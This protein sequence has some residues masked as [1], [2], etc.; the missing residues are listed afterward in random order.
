MGTVRYYDNNQRVRFDGNMD[1]CQNTKLTPDSMVMVYDEA[2]HGPIEDGLP[3]RI[4]SVVDG[5]AVET[6]ETG[7]HAGEFD[8]TPAR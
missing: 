3:Y 6:I 7:P 4:K 5:G 1:L 8:Y 2:T